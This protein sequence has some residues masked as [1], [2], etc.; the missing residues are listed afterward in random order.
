MLV[1]TARNLPEDHSNMNNYFYSLR[2]SYEQFF[3]RLNLIDLI[4]VSLLSLVFLGVSFPSFAFFGSSDDELLRV[5]KA[6]I[7]EAP[8]VENG[9]IKA[10]WKIADGYYLYGDKFIFSSDVPGIELGDPTKPAGK[11]KAD[12]Y[13]GDVEIHRDS[14]TLSIPVDNTTSLKEFTLNTGFQGCADIGVCY[15]PTKKSVTLALPSVAQDMLGG[16]AAS[17]QTQSS[18]SSI[19][20]LSNLR[21]SLGIDEPELLLAD[22]AFAFVAGINENEIVAQWRVADDYYLYKDKIKLE[23]RNTSA[24]LEA[25]DLP[26]GVIEDDPILGETESYRG[27]LIVGFPIK[28]G[29]NLPADAVLYAEYQGC[30]DIGVCYPPIK[31][32]FKLSSLTSVNPATVKT[33]TTTTK[34]K[35]TPEPITSSAANNTA[36]ATPNNTSAIPQNGFDKII[37]EGNLL[38][39]TLAALGFGLLLAFTA[40]M[41]PMIP[42]LSSIIVGH[43][44][45]M[46][47]AKGFTLSLVYVLSLAITFGIIGA[48]TALFFKGVGLQA[49]FQSPWLLIPFVLLFIALSLSMFGFFDIQLPSSLQSKLNA[50]SHRQKGGKFLGVAIMGSLSALIIGP[51]GGPVLVAVMGYAAATG[52]MINGFVAMFAL[53]LGMGLPLLLLGIGGGSLLPKAGGWMT[54]VKA[55]GGVILLAIALVFLERMP[56]I[57][58]T[59]LV[60]LLWAALFIISGIFIGAFDAINRE[61]SNWFRL[62]K[63]LGLFMVFYGMLVMVGGM[64][65]GSKATDPLHNSRLFSS[66]TAVQIHEYI[67]VKTVDDLN[68]EIKRATSQGKT[69]MLDFY[70]DWCVYCKYFDQYVFPDPRVQQSL[71]NTV[72]L[73]ADV[74]K[75]DEEDNALMKYVGVVLPPAIIFYDKNGNEM[76]QL[77]VIGEMKAEQFSAHIKNKL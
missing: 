56:G 13:F 31:K 67:K 55:T 64:T 30:A 10:T 14:I 61:R 25:P 53:G 27:D 68:R 19:N 24:K 42:I 7:L 9:T 33:T 23:L 17:E 48:L 26:E 15:P 43:G 72:L 35:A 73:K 49:Y 54:A 41:Y 3:L 1:K 57:F 65:G 75:T 29:A 18:S 44:E 8:I 34:T 39:I 40:C 46:N 45:K 66:S 70:A 59:S 32:T 47:V 16:L 11:I 6:F 71:N 5:E 4:R 74:T 36:T 50:I 76:R 63:G 52:N 21:I 20:V 77:R 2:K 28:N 22:D 62:W 12:P 58:P 69:V 60:M 38:T 51:C 37:S